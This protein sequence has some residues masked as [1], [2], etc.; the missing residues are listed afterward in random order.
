MVVFVWSSV[1]SPLVS[2]SLTG[3]APLLKIILDPTLPS[4]SPVKGLF[5]KID[6]LNYK[7]HVTSAIDDI[8]KYFRK[9]FLPK[10]YIK[11][12]SI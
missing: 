8:S 4:P 10:S 12:S 3:G 9:T 7:Q 11:T 1:L 6:V 2:S 5:S